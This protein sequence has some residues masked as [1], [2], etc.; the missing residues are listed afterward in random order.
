METNVVLQLVQA[1]QQAKGGGHEWL[2]PALITAAVGALMAF[3]AFY[4]A[5]TA[6]LKATLSESNTK[7]AKTTAEKTAGEVE[8]IHT[9]VN[10]RDTVMQAELKKLREEILSLSKEKATMQEHQRGQL[11]LD[12]GKDAATSATPAAVVEIVAP[13]SAGGGALSDDQLAKW[14]QTL[15]KEQA[16]RAKT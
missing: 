8:K 11:V 4:Q 1:L 5:R 9:A 14:I 10:S 13:A 6:A 15:E 7:D 2:S 16:A 3:A 12:A